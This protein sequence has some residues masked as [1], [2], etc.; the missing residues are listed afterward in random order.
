MFDYL[1]IVDDC[2]TRRIAGCQAFTGCYDGLIIHHEI[3]A[4]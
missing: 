4:I 2:D 1:T 3:G